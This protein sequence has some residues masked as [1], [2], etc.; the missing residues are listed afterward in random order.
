[1]GEAKATGAS[2]TGCARQARRAEKG[3][4]NME[5]FGMFVLGLV[6]CGVASSQGPAV[7]VASPWEHV[8]KSTEPGPD[9]AVSLQ[10][11]RNEYEP[12]RMIV[13]AGEQPL[14]DVNVVVTA[15]KG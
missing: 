1:M 2:V 5:K 4:E 3:D 12:F 11:G 9:R 13:R 7:W 8:L 15:L 14:A 10:A 6:I